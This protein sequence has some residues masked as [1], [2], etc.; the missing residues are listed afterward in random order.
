MSSN[1]KRGAKPNWISLLITVIA[2]AIVIFRMGSGEDATVSNPTTPTPVPSQIVT[3]SGVDEQDM[4]MTLSV[5]EVGKADCLVLQCDGETMIIDGGN[6]EDEA[7][8]LG[9]LKSMGIE[10]FDYLVNTHPHEDHLGSLDAVINAYPV[11]LALISPKEHTTRAYERMLDALEDNDVSVAVPQ[12]GDTIKLG[13]AVLTVLAPEADAAYEGYNDWSIVL[14]AQYGDV[15][16]LLMGDAETPVESDL[17]DSGIDL[18]ADVLKVGHHGSNTSSK[19]TFLAAVNP[20]YAVITCDYTQEY[21]DPN[22]KVVKRLNDLGIPFMR[23]D[24]S[25]V[26]TI[27]TDGRDIAINTERE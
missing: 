18:Q 21:G 9:Q 1:R 24:Q 3:H 17:L 5:L 11:D 12:V 23:T 25:G 6:E 2:L 19:K 13:G 27:Y 15:K 22:A 10:K 16:Y 4:G 20:T 14:M 8:I 7:Y 26:V